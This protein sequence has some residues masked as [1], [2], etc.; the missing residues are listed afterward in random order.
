MINTSIRDS[1]ISVVIPTLNGGAT[2]AACLDGIF[3]QTVR[4]SL[5]VIVVDSGSRDNTLEIVRGYPIRLFH[6]EPNEFNHGAVRNFGA[7]NARGEFV[8]MTV[9]DAR[10]VDEH[11]MERMLRHFSRAEVAAVCG[12]QIVPHEPDKN[13]LQWFRSYSEPKLETVWFPDPKVFETL[14]AKEKLRLCGWDD[15]TAMYR[16]SALQQIPFRPVN[17]AEDMVWARDALLAGFAR[18]YDYSARVYHYHQETSSFRFRRTY[19]IQFHTQQFFGVVPPTEPLIKRIAG[20]VYRSLRRK[21]CP[22]R[23]WHWMFYNVRLTL[24]ESFAAFVF[25]I[26]SRLGKTALGS[27]L[28]NWLC[29]TAPQ[30]SHRVSQ[31]PLAAGEGLGASARQSLKSSG[32]TGTH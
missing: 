8:V 2:I 32:A 25:F 6:I 10:P 11:W 5:E 13:P 30:A 18:V 26:V 14:P 28:N 20:D 9:Q 7:H 22:S 24:S 17:F 4:G 31:R 3:Q 27:T 21:Y 16:R 23:R 15:V 29:S 1:K 12:Q 19:T